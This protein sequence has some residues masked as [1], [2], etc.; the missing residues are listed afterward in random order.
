MSSSPGFPGRREE[1]GVPPAL[2]GVVSRLLRSGLA[3]ACVLFLLGVVAYL[4][5]GV[6]L[7]AGHG[8]TSPSDGL[9]N[10]LLRGEPA[11]FTFAGLIVLL[12]TPVARVVV[13]VG[14]FASVGDRPFTFFTLFVLAVVL[15]TI[16]V[17]ILR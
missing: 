8:A 12:A 10:G 14:L 1:A 6:G 9:L 15:A 5:D 2:R 7:G 3:I 11:A 17:G 13:S 4:H 16:A